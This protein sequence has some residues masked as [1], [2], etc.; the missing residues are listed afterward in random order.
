MNSY[1]PIKNGPNSLKRSALTLLIASGPLSPQIATGQPADYSLVAL[2]D[3]VTT[4]FDAEGI[5]DNLDYSWST[6]TS[7]DPRLS[8]H[9]KRLKQSMPS[10]DVHEENMAVAGSVAADTIT[11][12]QQMQTLHP[13]YVTILTGGNDFCAQINQD[14]DYLQQFKQQLNAT[15]DYLISQSPDV[16]I[17]LAPIPNFANLYTIGKA[18]HCEGKWFIFNICPKFLSANNTDVDRQLFL[19]TIQQANLVIYDLAQ[20][21]PQNVKF[22]TGLDQARFTTDDLSKIDCFHPSVAGQNYLAQLTWSSGWF[23]R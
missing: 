16:K 19:S 20:S 22:A 11:Q 15:L 2:G 23:A 10:V 5:F 13:N 21:R 3:S 18:N 1:A 6:G 17:L 9:Y 4:A 8:S 14:S 12:A 7:T